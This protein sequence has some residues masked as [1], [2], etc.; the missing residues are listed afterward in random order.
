MLEELKQKAHLKQDGEFLDNTIE[1]MSI[2]QNKDAAAYRNIELKN[3][4][5]NVDGVDR[6]KIKKLELTVENL[7]NKLS[8][9]KDELM[10][11]RDENLTLK[12]SNDNHIYINEKLNKALKK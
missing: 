10:K 12:A 5:K 7:N 11:V 4:D 1:S 9:L 3:S 2:F 6:N 8:K